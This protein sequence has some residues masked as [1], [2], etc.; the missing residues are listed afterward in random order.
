MKIIIP[1][2]LFN[3]INNCLN[4]N[5]KRYHAFNFYHYY[6]TR[7]IT[8][9]DIENYSPFI[10]IS[11]KKLI[12]LFGSKYF[13]LFLQNLIDYEI[14]IRQPYTN[15]AF[16]SKDPNWA[17]KNNQ[18]FGYRF[19]SCLMDFSSLRIINIKPNKAFNFD[20]KKGS[21]RKVIKVLKTIK[22][23][24]DELFKYINNIDINNSILINQNIEGDLLTVKNFNGGDSFQLTKLKAIESLRFNNQLIEY[25]NR[26]YFAHLN[27]FIE[28]KNFQLKISTI[29][30]I[31]RLL[32]GGYYAS[33]NATNK[34]LDT[35]ITNLKSALLKEGIITLDNKQLVSIDL[36]NSQ[37]TL[38]CFLLKNLTDNSIFNELLDQY[39]FPDIDTNSSDFNDFSEFVIDGKIYDEI[40]E[41]TG[42][43]SRSSAKLLFL[44]IMFSK[45]SWSD[46]Y[47][48]IIKKRFPTIITWMDDFKKLNGHHETLAEL[49]QKVESQIF[50]DI[51]YQKLFMAKIKALTKHDSIICK[52]S[53]YKMAYGIITETLDEIGLKYKLDVEYYKK[54]V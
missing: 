52:I 37:P 28:Y 36:K 15:K 45:G 30:Q 48:S 12:D 14:I 51:I 19:N 20:V 4:T 27:K 17:E 44:K 3:A 8:N 18:P 54:S 26:Y 35:N 43:N 24:T 25:K 38:L 31:N 5:I 53:D 50:I 47:K 23:D 29:A 2:A 7:L 40:Q 41:I 1:Q 39:K 34:R 21:D 9:D 33:R 22:I 10:R 16:K 46:E 42:F 11:S 32:N 49:L 6:T 13:K